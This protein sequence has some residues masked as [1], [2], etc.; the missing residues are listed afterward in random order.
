MARVN[1]F[2]SIYQ[3]ESYKHAWRYP[4][5]DFPPIMDLEPT[6]R[7]NLACVHCPHQLMTRPQGEMAPFLFTEI[8]TEAAKHGCK[9]IRFILFGEPLLHP[10]LFKM[11]TFAHRKGLLTHLTTNG[12]LLHRWNVDAIL[13]SGLDSL[14][15][16][17]Q[18]IDKTGYEQLRGPH[19][20]EVIHNLKYIGNFDNRPYITLTTTI[21]DEKEPDISAFKGYWAAWADKVDVWETHLGAVQD[22][23][24]VKP[25]LSRER[26]HP[27]SNHPCNDVY[28][29]LN[30][31]FDGTVIPCCDISQMNAPYIVGKFPAQSLYQIWHGAKYTTLRDTIMS[32][33]A[34]PLCQYCSNKF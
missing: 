28:N 30:V 33:E 8:V 26:K 25:F 24:R 6:N 11:I 32:G 34:L 14:V 13:K 16:S 15:I 20:D 21:L 9:G 4:L 19:Y 22:I 10:R 18:G 23:P 27:K 29:K 7:C 2:H 5:V 31:L 12:V 17:L 3:A 1:P